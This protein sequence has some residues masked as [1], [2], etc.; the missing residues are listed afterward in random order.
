MSIQC[1]VMIFS[2]TFHISNRH[3]RRTGH[4]HKHLLRSANYLV[5]RKFL[6]KRNCP[7][8]DYYSHEQSIVNCGHIVLSVVS[9][10][11]TVMRCCGAKIINYLGCVQCIFTLYNI[12]IAGNGYSFGPPGARQQPVERL[13]VAHVCDWQWWLC[14]LGM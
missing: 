11:V 4:L 3:N 7:Q 1:S 6:M 2:H 10:Y 9:K 8:L 13:Q 12:Y 14:A 5:Y